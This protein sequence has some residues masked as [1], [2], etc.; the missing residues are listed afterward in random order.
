MLQTFRR[1][2]NAL[3]PSLNQSDLSSILKD[4]NPANLIDERVIALKKLMDW[5]R[6]PVKRQNTEGEN[7]HLESRNIRYKFFLQYLSRNPIERSYFAD[8]LKELLGQGVAARLY[9]MTGV[10]ENTGFFSELVDRLVVRMLPHIYSERDLAELFKL[11]FTEEEDAEW[12]EASGGLILPPMMELIREHNISLESLRDDINE[13][14]IILGAQ[15]SSIGVS[16]GIRKR[17]RSQTLSD[18]PFVRLN[19]VINGQGSSCQ[20]V[21][22]EVAEG[23]LHLKR[24]R[25]R[26]ES[27][28]V[29]VDLIYNIERLNALLQRVEILVRLSENSSENKEQMISHFLGHLIRAEIHRRGVRDFLAEHMSMLAKKI[30]ERAGEK[31]DHY[32]AA[33]PAEKHHLFVAAS[34]AGVLTAFTAIIKVLIGYVHFPLLFEGFF[35]FINYAVGFLLMQRWHLALSSKQP[36]FMA[37]ALSRKFEDFMQTKEL[38]DV[39]SEV[40]KITFSQILASVGNLLCVIPVVMVLD[41][42]YFALSGGHLV[43]PDYA[44]TIID[45]HGLWTSGTLFY[46][47]FTGV[48]LWMSS[49]V[50]GWIENWIIFRNIPQMMNESTFLQSFLGKEKARKFTDGFASMAGAATGNV[51]IAL[52]LAVPIIIGKFTG[53]PLD[54]RHVTLA[55]GTITLALNSLPWTLELIPTVLSML[56][57]VAVMGMLNF[58]VSF[59]C[60]IR[61]AALARGVPPRYL[62]IIFR[63][64]FR[65]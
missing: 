21:L 39:S 3:K 47:A 14:L 38:G 4:M 45:K 49:V 44:Q 50:A 2:R 34:W 6:L 11:I 57:S 8:N 20:A 24:V 15:L 33:T 62:K 64:A 18:S 42:G 52:F 58:G 31:G 54:I 16:K 60:S 61:M 37:S 19:K 9:C 30:V 51:T 17:L 5:I 27:T 55:A 40:K 56:L 35:Y 53:I 10:S 28:G 1:L 7:T 43:S 41:W 59:Y 65:R 26:A 22:A 29:S 48:L 25:D 36:A 23:Q 12:F 32:I 13:A 63:Y 46:A